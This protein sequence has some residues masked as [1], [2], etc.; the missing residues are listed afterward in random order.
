MILRGVFETAGAAHLRK[1]LDLEHEPLVEGP[2]REEHASEDLSPHAL[3]GMVPSRSCCSNWRVRVRPFPTPYSRLR[4]PPT[5]SGTPVLWPTVAV[6]SRVRS[7]RS[8]RGHPCSGW[9]SRRGHP[10]LRGGGGGGKAV[11][12][13]ASS[14]VP[15]GRVGVDSDA[16]AIPPQISAA[17]RPLIVLHRSPSGRHGPSN[18]KGAAARQRVADT[19][20][21]RRLPLAARPPRVPL[22]PAPPGRRCG[23]EALGENAVDGHTRTG[24]NRRA[25]SGVCD[26]PT[27]A[28]V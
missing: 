10:R 9:N 17:S 2:L 13:V 25:S 24:Q 4:G 28:A 12:E 27:S 7:S 11:P 21:A 19:P 26:R 23:H 5:P 3:P 18:A 8:T 16:W 15:T 6:D 14:A 1:A 20:R 22:D